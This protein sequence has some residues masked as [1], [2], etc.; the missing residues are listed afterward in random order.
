MPG[1]MPAL[2]SVAKT[3]REL[4]GNVSFR[5]FGLGQYF[6][7]RQPRRSPGASQA[8]RSRHYAH[9]T[10]HRR[11]SRRRSRSVG[12][13]VGDFF[14]QQFAVPPAHRPRCYRGETCGEV[15]AWRCRLHAQARHGAIT[16]DI[17][18]RR[19]GFGGQ[20]QERNERLRCPAMGLYWPAKSGAL[21][22]K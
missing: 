6:T 8:G 9:K 5:S 20:L 15:S 18:E 10:A 3:L 19:H 2:C 11:G 17:L 4:V 16:P 12:D 14:E 7:G 22:L 13:G 1:A 21:K